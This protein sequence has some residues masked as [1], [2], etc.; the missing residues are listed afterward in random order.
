MGKD[1]AMWETSREKDEREAREA[2]ERQ[3]L[4]EVVKSLGRTKGG[5]HFLQ[6]LVDDVCGIFAPGAALPFA[7]GLLYREGRRA[8][9]MEIFSI[10]REA[11]IAGAVCEM[12]DT[13][14]DRRG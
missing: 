10:C 2:M 5:I 4:I 9:G 1:P 11:G 7:D 13:K 3:W 12:D 6:W 14:E 8:V